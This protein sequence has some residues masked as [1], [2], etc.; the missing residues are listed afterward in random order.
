MNKC[1]FML[2]DQEEVRGLQRTVDDHTH[3]GPITSKL[4]DLEQLSIEQFSTVPIQTTWL[5][6][7]LCPKNQF[8]KNN[9]KIFSPVFYF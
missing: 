8:I 7:S 1:I 6:Q 3:T 2:S 9:A 5:L 4:I